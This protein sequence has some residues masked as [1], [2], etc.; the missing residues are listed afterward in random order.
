MGVFASVVGLLLGLGLA[1]GLFKLFDAAG[2]TLPNNGLTLE[3]RTI[4]VALA[5]GIIVT[6]LASVYPALRATMVP[7]IAA[8]REGATL[9]SEP[10]DA[11]RGT[12]RA[13]A[14]TARG[15]RRARRLHLHEAARRRSSPSCSRCVFLV[16]HAL[17]VG[18][19]PV[20]DGRRARSVRPR[21]RRVGLRPVRLGR[22][23]ARVLLW[24]GVGVL[25]VF[26][27]FARVATPLVPGLS[28][29]MSP[30]ARWSVFALN[31]LVW[32]FWTFPYWCLRYGLWGPGAIWK[33]VIAF[34]F[35]ALN[36]ILLAI[37]LVMAIR[38]KADELETGV[39]GRVPGRDPG[40]APRIESVAR[41]RAETRSG[42][43]RRPQR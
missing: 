13:I 15:R 24:I 39:A 36:V 12:A 8:V 40:P 23:D 11:I 34:L 10:L 26:F 35:G 32:P 21:L 31:V 9:P 43:H 6:V 22:R 27:G 37:V 5:L 42:R 25:L 14:V 18:P 20:E 3:T 38:K 41:T 4:V 19:L 28:S 33:R 30:I 2:F 16:A 29:F 17:R 7:P 1:K